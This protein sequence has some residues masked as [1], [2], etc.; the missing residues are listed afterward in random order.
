MRGL[1]IPARG[2]PAYLS[3]RQNESSGILRARILGVSV[4]RLIQNQLRKTRKRMRINDLWHCIAVSWT[5]TRQL[6]ERPQDACRL[7][8]PDHRHHHRATAT[9]TE[10]GSS[11]IDRPMARP[12]GDPPDRSGSIEAGRGGRGLKAPPTPMSDGA[13]ATGVAVFLIMA[14][15]LFGLVV[16]LE[17]TLRDEGGCVFE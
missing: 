7:R 1:T 6:P 3:T 12:I 5:N 2:I 16:F 17:L 15:C 4:V 10:P 11:T 9:P 8:R 13:T 14:P